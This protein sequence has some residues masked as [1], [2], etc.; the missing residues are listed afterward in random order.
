[1]AWRGKGIGGGT[2]WCSKG[3]G[4]SARLSHCWRNEAH[5][6]VAT[7]G[8]CSKS[9]GP[10]N[11]GLL[12]KFESPMESDLISGPRLETRISPHPLIYRT[13]HEVIFLIFLNYFLIGKYDVA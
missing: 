9:E 2:A 8:T 3:S 4:G 12:A 13:G 10:T 1:V 7:G 11:A 6:Q 5:T